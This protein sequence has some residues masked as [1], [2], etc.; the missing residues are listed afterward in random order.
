MTGE[1]PGTDA[2]RRLDAVVSTNDGFRIAEEDLALRG[3]GEFFGSRQSG[4]P[5]LQVA[6][7]VRDRDYLMEAKEEARLLLEE[8]RDLS[9][10][11][12][13]ALRD[14][15]NAAWKNKFFLAATG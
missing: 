13:R 9:A 10:P 7:L 2:L 11:G 3:P 1:A 6:D 8:D 15:V 14:A 4:L 12:H 5:R